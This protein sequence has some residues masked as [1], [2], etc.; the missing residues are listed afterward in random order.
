MKLNFDKEAEEQ[1]E[2]S[3]STNNGKVEDRLRAMDN[4]MKAQHKKN[5]S[6]KE[7]IQEIQEMKRVNIEAQ[8]K[9]SDCWTN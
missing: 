9:H 2:K 5:L 8:K 1:V 4:R 3:M 7:E 6:L